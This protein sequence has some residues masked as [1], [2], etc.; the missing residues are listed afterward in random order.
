GRIDYPT[1]YQ[2]AD[3]ATLASLGV[4]KVIGMTSTYDHRVI[5]G[6]ESGEL[7]AKIEELLIGR[8]DFY[9]EVFAS[10]RVPYEPVRWTADRGAVDGDAGRLGKQAPALRLIHMYRVRRHLLADLNPLGAGKDLAHHELDPGY[11]GLC[12]WNPD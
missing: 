1:E 11:Q 9:E 8:D 4:G 5:Q 10:L 6:A 12:K 7:L 2:G 3:P